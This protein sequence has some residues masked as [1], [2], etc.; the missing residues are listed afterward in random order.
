MSIVLIAQSEIPFRIQSK[1]DIVL[2]SNTNLRHLHRVALSG[3]LDNGDGI[4]AIVL[5][6]TVVIFPDSRLRLRWRKTATRARR[7]N[8]RAASEDFFLFPRRESFQTIHDSHRSQKTAFR[9]AKQT[10]STT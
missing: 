4:I 9:G 8:G 7:P 6:R 10:R 5:D 3:Q 1:C 2:E